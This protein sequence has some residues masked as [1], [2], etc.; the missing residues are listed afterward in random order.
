MR[1]EYH[2]Q[3]WAILEALSTLAPGPELVPMS[4]DDALDAAGIPRDR[5]NRRW[6]INDLRKR[7][8][9]V[10]DSPEGSGKHVRALRITSIGK[11]LLKVYQEQGEAAAMEILPERVNR[12]RKSASKAVPATASTVP[13]PDNMTALKQAREFLGE[14]ASADDLITIAHFIA[15]GTK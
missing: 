4:S 2:W 12:P 7:S 10:A 9:I 1:T 11:R 13:A 8:L 3:S 6:F 5:V 14:D 15:G